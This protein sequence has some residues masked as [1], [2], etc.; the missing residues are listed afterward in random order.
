MRK[1]S[2]LEIYLDILKAVSKKSQLTHI[3]NLANLSWKETK[4]NLEILIK[5]GFVKTVR[6]PKRE[7][8]YT[9]TEKGLEAL[10]IIQKI[11][12]ILSSKE[13]ALYAAQFNIKNAY[14]SENE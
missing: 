11:V 4:K 7:V 10:E 6:T 2:K 8:Q 12:D 5:K 1:R 9:L 3:G 14:K 13:Q